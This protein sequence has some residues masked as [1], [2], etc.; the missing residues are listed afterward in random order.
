MQIP[1]TTLAT[2]TPLDICQGFPLFP[3]QGTIRAGISQESDSQSLFDFSPQILCWIVNASAGYDLDLGIC[4]PAYAITFEAEGQQQGST[5]SLT[6]S[7]DRIFAGFSFGVYAGLNFS[8]SIEQMKLKFVWDGW[9][10]HLQ[11]TW[12]SVANFNPSLGFDLLNVIEFV[13]RQILGEKENWFTKLDDTF[14][15]AA[16]SWGFY[17]QEGNAFASQGN[18]Q[19]F[20]SVAVPIDILHLLLDGWP[21]LEDLVD[22]LEEL[23]GGLAAG[24]QFTIAVPTTV[25]VH[26]ALLDS[27]PFNTPTVQG[28]TVTMQGTDPVTTTPQNLSIFLANQSNFQLE[29]DVFAEFW[30]A[31]LV[32]FSMTYDLPNVF[33]VNNIHLDTS[34]TYIQDLSAAI[35]NPQTAGI[36]EIVLEPWAG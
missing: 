20:P 34:G 4:G 23:A 24:P 16:A 5:L 3:E 26:G 35:G 32:N 22:K 13:V 30:I 29:F 36:P 14:P 19:A 10:T 8:L 28:S 31:Q 7:E 17:D 6:L 18:F 1:S 11:T 21:E 12:E 27:A 9:H 2:S 15:N 33:E 25:S